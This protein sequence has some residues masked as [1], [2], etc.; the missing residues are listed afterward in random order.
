MTVHS[1]PSTPVLSGS[2]TGD[3]LTLSFS[4]PAISG[5]T[6]YGFYLARGG[7][8]MTSNGSVTTNS[9]SM[10]V[11]ADPTTWT[12]YVWAVN[13]YGCVSSNSNTV[14]IVFSRPNPPNQCSNA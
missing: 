2:R 11:T 5:A 12:F 4:W 9:F 14:N 10:D 3:G 13:A 7:V 1:V 6:S 8:V